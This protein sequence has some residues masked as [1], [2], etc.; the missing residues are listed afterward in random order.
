MFVALVVMISMAI[1]LLSGAHTFAQ[2][3]SG[4]LNTLKVSPVRSD[5]EISPGQSKT[6]QI[7]ITNL[8]NK[9]VTVSA[10]ENDF[11]SGDEN[12]T[13]ALILDADK[14]A[15]THSLKRFMT[16]L[17]DVTILANKAKLVDVVITVPASAQAGGYFGAVRFAPAN[18]DG[19]AQVNLS[20]SV[21]S[22]ILLNVP[23]DAIEKLNLTDFTI[24]Q[25]GKSNA[26][27]TS[28]DNLASTFR[29]ENKGSVQLGPIGK[30]SV[31]KWGTIISETDFNA[32]TPR[33]LI[34]PDGARRWTV[35]ID[36]ADGFGHYTVLAT[37]TYGK[38][39][40]TVEVVRS[41]WV[42]PVVYMIGAAVALILLAAI[43]FF[44]VF[45]IRRR[46]NRRSS[47]R[48]RGG[49]SVN[50]RRRR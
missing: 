3:S 46:L 29:F 34:L 31:K 24:Q 7:T 11:V 27:F 16:P 37:L 40:E 23:G 42:I 38:N 20:G 21:A 26:F 17:K 2:T 48:S 35:P 28:S 41:F 15:P 9:D 44:I 12:G 39:N 14:Y 22:L 36:K 8:T 32:Q 49:L 43:I 30:I 50:G 18:P 13:P 33:D 1:A 47:N 45:F 4:A 6:V 10:I 25:N 19:G 5:I